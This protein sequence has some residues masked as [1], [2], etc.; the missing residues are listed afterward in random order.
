MTAQTLHYDA[1]AERI[2]VS[3]QVSKG[4]RVLLRVHNETMPDLEPVVQKRLEREGAVVE[5][6]PPA[7]RQVGPVLAGRDA[8]GGQGGQGLADACQRDAEAL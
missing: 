2:A 5:I 8:I 4:E 7:G 6:L 1:M 3:G